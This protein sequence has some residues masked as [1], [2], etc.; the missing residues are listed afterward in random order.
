MWFNRYEKRIYND[1]Y[2]SDYDLDVTCL[3]KAKSFMK[4]ANGGVAKVCKSPE[5][6]KL[7]LNFI[8]AQCM[9]QA[10]Y[11]VSLNQTAKC[12]FAS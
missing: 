4:M 12:K 9:G 7:Y 2:G 8:N 11:P 10:G 5:E 3:C 6:L 1:S